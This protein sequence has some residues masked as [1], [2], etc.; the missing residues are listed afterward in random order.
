MRFVDHV[1]TADADHDVF[2]VVRHADDFMGNNLPDGQDE[3]VVVEQQ[4]VALNVDAVVQLAFRP[5][6]NK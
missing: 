1:R 3:I 5:F 4:L 6:F 2:R